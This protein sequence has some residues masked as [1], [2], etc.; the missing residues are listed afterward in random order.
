[1]VAS[2]QGK[3]PFHKTFFFA[4]QSKDQKEDFKYLKYSFDFT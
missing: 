1:M 3:Y 4:L 2:A